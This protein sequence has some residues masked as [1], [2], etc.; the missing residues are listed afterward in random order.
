MSALTEEFLALLQASGWSASEAARRL[1]LD[2]SN[3]SQYKSGGSPSK[4]T[5]EL[6]KL[7]LAQEKPE[8]IGPSHMQLR[9]V[10]LHAVDDMVHAVE[11]LRE[12][13]LA[14]ERCAKRLKPAKPTS[15]KSRSAAGALLDAADQP[16][17][18]P[19]KSPH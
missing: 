5:L 2:R 1:H 16:S 18:P 9:D 6:F 3:I 11:E 15:S 7:I 13:F 10:P 12:K 4:Q 19:S 14:V 17:G 8:A